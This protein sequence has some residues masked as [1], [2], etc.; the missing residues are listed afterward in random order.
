MLSCQRG[1]IPSYSIVDQGSHQF[2]TFIFTTLQRYI[3]LGTNLMG[4]PPTFLMRLV[5]KERSVSP[6]SSQN[7]TM[8][9]KSWM[10]SIMVVLGLLLLP[11]LLLPPSAPYLVPPNGT[12]RAKSPDA[13]LSPHSS[14]L[15]KA[16]SYIAVVDR[17]RIQI[18]HTA[19]PVQKANG[20]L[21]NEN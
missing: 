17:R 12:L 19:R 8:K 21:S 9:R 6:L 5:L 3:L 15:T 1:R 7:K 20:F 10:S 14:L 4:S 11:L 18:R 13:F 2:G 16:P